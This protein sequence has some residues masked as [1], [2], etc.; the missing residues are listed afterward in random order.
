MPRT[1][2]KRHFLMCRP[3]Y[4][5][6][7]YAINPWMDTSAPVD[8]ELALKQWQ[9]LRETLARLGHTVHVL[10]AEDGLPDMVYAANG[11][12]VVGGRGAERVARGHDALASGVLLLA[13]DL[14]DGRSLADAVHAHEEPHVRRPSGVAKAL[15]VGTARPRKPS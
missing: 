3:T 1:A 14:A 7:F 12:T 2:T 10:P 11:A 13:G 4:F 15:A 8:G 6:V 9:L 5:D